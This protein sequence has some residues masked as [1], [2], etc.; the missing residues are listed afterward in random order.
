MGKVTE[1]ESL[2]FNEEYQI[3]VMSELKKGKDFAFS[4]NEVQ[5]KR[6][7][8]MA[9]EIAKKKTQK[10][11]SK[12]VVRHVNFG[13][14]ETEESSIVGWKVVQLPTPATA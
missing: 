1:K 6:I 12:F 9:E 3:T 11:G 14:G 13:G 7:K 5:Y 10:T 4:Y 2:Y 8:E